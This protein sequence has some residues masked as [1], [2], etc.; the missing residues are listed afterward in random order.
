MKV[1]NRYPMG[2]YMCLL[3]PQQSYRPS[4][5]YSFCLRTHFQSSRPFAYA[6]S[7]S[8]SSRPFAY[9][10]ASSFPPFCSRAH[11]QSSRPFAY[12]IISQPDKLTVQR[13]EPSLEEKVNA[14][15]QRRA[16][17]SVCLCYGFSVERKQQEGI[18]FSNDNEDDAN[19]NTNAS[20]NRWAAST[21][22]T[23]KGNS[24]TVT[25]QQR[26]DMVLHI[27]TRFSVLHLT[28]TCSRNG[29][30]LK[31]QQNKQSRKGS[32]WKNEWMKVTSPAVCSSRVC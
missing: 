21:I 17:Q 32:E 10:L 23:A 18:T 3:I 5:Y 2:T 20:N 13:A 11:F 8:R 24:T 15:G 30:S 1:I 29:T 12:T 22:R 28:F 27:A 25:N 16:Y 7:S 19:D 31:T 14:S 26:L 4:L 9:A 6:L